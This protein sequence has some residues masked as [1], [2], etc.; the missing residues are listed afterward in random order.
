MLFLHKVDS[1]LC[2][3]VRL[4]QY[5]LSPP[6][7]RIMAAG[8]P[9]HAARNM[10]LNR[11][12]ETHPIRINARYE[13]D[14]ANSFSKSSGNLVYRRT[15]GQTMRTDIG[16]NPVYPPS[17]ERGYKKFHTKKSTNGPMF[18]ELLRRDFPYIP[19][20]NATLVQQLFFVGNYWLTFCWWIISSLHVSMKYA[21]DRRTVYTLSTI[22]V[23]CLELQSFR[24]IYLKVYY[25]LSIFLTFN[26]V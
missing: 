14:W 21:L 1:A 3:L 4:I 24:M 16:L 19:Q 17:V 8:H 5:W 26:H 10:R 20:V 25:I 13:I 12:Q 11:G 23:S 9:T 2:Y 6:L 18:E 22:S 15:D 7:I